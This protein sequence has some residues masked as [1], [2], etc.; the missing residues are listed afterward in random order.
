MPPG[1]ASTDGDFTLPVPLVRQGDNCGCGLAAIAMCM[2]F[3]GAPVR[4]RDLE[5]HRLVRPE[6]LT[7]WGVGPG[8][9]GR[10]A[11]EMGFPVT[12]I[13]S[14]PRDVGRLFPAA[15][16]RWVR[17]D[18]RKAD[19]LAALRSGIPAVA[20]IPRKSK[21]FAGCTQH[22]SHWVVV[23]GVEG[24]EFVLHDPAP[25]R[26]ATRCV[27]GYWDDWGCSLLVVHPRGHATLFG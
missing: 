17:R 4:L 7:R 22:G 23:I 15:G 6:F 27:P 26:K 11:L 24:G 3:H 8:R 18:P 12:I 21:A 13:D 1:P 19:I 25:W 20:C 14:E 16:G 2:R 10:V 9:L 5:R